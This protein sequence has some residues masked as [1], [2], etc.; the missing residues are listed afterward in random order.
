MRSPTI[1]WLQKYKQAKRVVNWSDG[2]SSILSAVFSS[3]SFGSA[4]SLVGLP[5]KIPLG[6]AGGC[7]AL[8]SSGL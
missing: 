5:A 6:G 4:L 8:L 3:A 7:F 2:I 1:E